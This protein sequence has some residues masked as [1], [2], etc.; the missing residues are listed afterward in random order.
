MAISKLCLQLPM[1]DDSGTPL[2][3]ACAGDQISLT[4]SHSNS[5]NGVTLWIFTPSNDCNRRSLDHN[6]PDDVPPCGPFMFENITHISQTR[7][8]AL[9]STAVFT[10]NESISNTLVECRDNAG[11]AYN[12]VGNITICVVG[13]F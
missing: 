9:S 13:E 12:Q 1:H 2:L 6:N 8:S 11:N 4:C 10:A 3:I 7:S 5:D